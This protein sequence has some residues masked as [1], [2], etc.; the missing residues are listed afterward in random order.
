[1]RIRSPSDFWC[2]LLFVALGTL[3][4]VLAQEY[5]FGTSARMGPGY[6]PALLGGLLALIGLTLSVPALFAAGDPLPRIH[7]RPLVMVLLGIAAF[8][9]TLEYLGLVAAIV[10]LVV[11]GGLADRDLRPLEIV[12][13]AAFMV[14]FS[15]LIFVVLLGLPFRL[16]PNL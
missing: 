11:I 6:F 7:L 5:R 9:V 8:G 1:L 15:T 16:W 4:V 3:T 10:A 13:V 12:G 2:G 14:A